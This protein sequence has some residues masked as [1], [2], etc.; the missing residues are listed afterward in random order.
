MMAAHLFILSMCTSE[1]TVVGK[2]LDVVGQLPG[3]PAL[4]AL[5]CFVARVTGVHLHR[6]ESELSVKP[7]HSNI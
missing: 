5:V 4:C 7:Q 6:N 2:L 1:C 3:Y